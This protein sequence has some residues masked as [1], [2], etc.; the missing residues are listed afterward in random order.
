M[1]TGGFERTVYEADYAVEFHPI[2]VQGETEQADI[3]SIQN[4]V[5]GTQAL[6]SP[7]SAIVSGGRKKL[8]LRARLVRF[9][10]TAPPT[11]LNYT[12]GQ[13]LT[14]PALSKAFYDAA[15]PGN[16]IN[17]LGGTGVVIGR[18]PESVR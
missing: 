13:T 6:T 14:I 5:G 18:V 12:P 15:I 10:F 17:Y 3:D 1:S 11:G 2:K 16:Q 4:S 8:G 9:E 7:I